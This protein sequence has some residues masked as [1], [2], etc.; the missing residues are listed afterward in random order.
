[1]CE[2][3]LFQICIL[4]TTFAPILVIHHS[5]IPHQ[6]CPYGRCT[7]SLQLDAAGGQFNRV[8]VHRVSQVSPRFHLQLHCACP[9]HLTGPHCTTPLD[10]CAR[11]VCPQPRV[12]LSTHPSP[13]PDMSEQLVRPPLSPVQS[14]SV[15]VTSSRGSGASSAIDFSA[16][17]CI[18]PPPRTGPNCESILPLVGGIEDEVCYTPACFMQR[19]QGSL[20]FTGGSFVYWRVRTTAHSS[21]SSWFEVSFSLRTRQSVA[22]LVNVQWNA[23]RAF[24]LRLAADGRLVVSA[25][26]LSDG[27]PA[28][29]WLVSPQ[30]VADGRWH[31]VRLALAKLDAWIDYKASQGEMLHKHV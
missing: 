27:L 20:Q 22:S 4:P 11:A 5:L 29:D 25:I 10:A 30:P 2:S 19:E 23:L 16:Y 18:C 1:F 26:G 9:L 14:L 13:G 28:R 3:A 15:G 7:T 21:E 8:E 12:C 6:T 31:R 17:Q 24:Q